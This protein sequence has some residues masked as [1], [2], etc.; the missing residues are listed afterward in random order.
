MLS[1]LFR[2]VPIW[3]KCDGQSDCGD[4]SDEPETC[5]P[6]VC[7]IGTFQCRDR[8]CTYPGF[9]CD[10][11]PDCP[12]S[13]DED[14]ALC[15]M[16]INTVTVINYDSVDNS[17]R[18][19]LRLLYTWN[20]NWNLR[21]YYLRSGLLFAEENYIYW[22][23]RSPQ[24]KPS[25]FRFSSDGW[26]IFQTLVKL[27]SVPVGDHRC[28]DNQFQCK[29]KKCIPVSYL[30]DG[31]E[32]CSDGSDE[33]TE[34]CSQLTCPPGQFRCNNGRCLPLSYVCDAQDDC[35]DASDEPYETCSK[36]DIKFWRK[37]RKWHKW[38]L[39]VIILSGGPRETSC[40]AAFWH[41]WFPLYLCLQGASRQK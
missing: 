28:E 24:E 25:C 30:C 8:N 14:A 31:F 34:T 36:S 18:E 29:N 11:N 27:L 6:R 33:V 7:P 21:C 12:D 15:S 2:C 32:D 1:L 20:L 38:P 9:I 16:M 5:P 40:L 26:F 41:P 35:G 19:K 10:A 22:W 39:I 17:D 13:S 4:G 3:W 37:T 23:T